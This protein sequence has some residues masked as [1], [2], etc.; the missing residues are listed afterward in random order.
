MYRCAIAIF[1]ANFYGVSGRMIRDLDDI[2]D[3]KKWLQTKDAR[4]ARLEKEKKEKL[5]RALIEPKHMMDASDHYKGLFSEENYRG[6][7]G[8]SMETCDT[9]SRVILMTLVTLRRSCP[10]F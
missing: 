3:F 7:Q 9:A 10:I 5:E 4:A 1:W 8:D 6:R 2:E